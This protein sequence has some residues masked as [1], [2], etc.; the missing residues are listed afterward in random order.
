MNHDQFDPYH[1]WL[2]IQPHEH[3]VNHYRLLGL[4]CFESD[5][6]LIRKA[7]DDLTRNQGHDCSEHQRI[8]VIP[9]QGSEE[10]CQDG[11]CQ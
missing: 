4:V 10:D 2:G 5:M 11:D 6:T 7:A 9:P 8:E 3:P 1:H